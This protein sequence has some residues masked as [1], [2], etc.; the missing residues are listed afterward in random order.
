MYRVRVWKLCYSWMMAQLGLGWGAVLLLKWEVEQ[1]SLYVTEF[2]ASL[3][4]RMWLLLCDV[5]LRGVFSNEGFV[6]IKTKWATT[7]HPT[8]VSLFVEH[9]PCA[10]W[11]ICPILAE[12][13][14]SVTVRIALLHSRPFTKSRFQFQLLCN[15][16]AFQRPKHSDQWREFFR[17]LACRAA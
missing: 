3:C 10:R 1:T 11:C 16:A 9:N 8:E 7:L 6:V 13:K 17:L 12:R 15:H 14:N 5:F 2:V 4:C